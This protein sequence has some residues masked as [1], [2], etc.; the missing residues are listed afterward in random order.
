MSRCNKEILG[1]KEINAILGFGYTV[2]HS[3]VMEFVEKDLRE[4]AEEH[5]L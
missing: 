2:S 4:H 5:K 3:L 1:F